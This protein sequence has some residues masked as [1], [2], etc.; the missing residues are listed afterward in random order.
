MIRVVVKNG[1]LHP[2]DPLPAEWS[3]GAEIE[4]SGAL[5][6]PEEWEAINQDIQELE[7]LLRQSPDDPDDWKR[8][9]EALAEADRLA[10]EQIRRQMELA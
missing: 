4:L 10:K 6:A 8:V 5:P 7:E 2:L 1:L 3:E 9:E